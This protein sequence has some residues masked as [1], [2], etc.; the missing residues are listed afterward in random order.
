MSRRQSLFTPLRLIIGAG[1]CYLLAL[2]FRGVLSPLF[3]ML[4]ALGALLELGFWK[5][6]LGSTWRR[7]D[8]D[9]EEPAEPN[10]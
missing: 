3:L 7:G 9:S 1:F 6:I 4:F 8:E 5:E 10:A 2:G